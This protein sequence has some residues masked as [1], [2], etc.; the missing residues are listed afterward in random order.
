MLWYVH[1]SADAQGGQK[2]VLD[3]LE[4]EFQAVL[5]HLIWV[6]GLNSC[7]LQEQ[8][9]LSTAEPPPDPRPLL[10]PPVLYTKHFNHL[11]DVN[12]K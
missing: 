6:L 7:L 3:C 9:M 5:S 10:Y 8:Y 4:L 2:N 11:R 1:M 12:L